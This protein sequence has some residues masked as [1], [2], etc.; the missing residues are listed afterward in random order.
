VPLS[1]ASISSSSSS[2]QSHSRPDV[3]VAAVLG[4]ALHRVAVLGGREG[5]PRSLG[6]VYGA[7]VT[8]FVGGGL[9]GV[10]RRVIDTPGVRSSSNGVAVSRDG[11]MLLV[12][13]TWG[14]TRAIHVF[15]VA[16]GS[17]HRIIGGWD[18]PPL[19][20]SLPR[21]VWIAD[22]G[23]V[24]VADAGNKRVMVLTPVLH[25]HGLVGVGQLDSPT[26]VCAN[27][28]VVVVSDGGAHRLSVFSR[29]DGALRH[30]IGVHGR[31][32]GELGYPLGLCFM[33]GDRHIAVADERN[34]RVS[35]FDVGGEFIRHVGVRVVD[36]PK[37]VACS[38]DG[39]LVVAD[40]GNRRVVVFRDDGSVVKTCG[41]GVYAG[42]AVVGGSLFAQDLDAEACVVFE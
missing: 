30:H 37:G 38:V 33:S 18:R 31:G 32:D 41:S 1:Q 25:F 14:S 4:D 16:D 13:D 29:G 28:D 40:A 15:N 26:G 11:S 9:R 27:A 19:H 17:L 21:Q 12:S 24:F 20:F 8:R 36:K 35:V 7:C 2:S 34:D 3:C 42:V 23:F 5:M 39:E 10:V 22:D 6:S